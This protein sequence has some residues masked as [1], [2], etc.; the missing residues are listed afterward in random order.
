MHDI[1]YAAQYDRKIVVER[2]VRDAREIECAV[3]G[4][5]DPKASVP[6]EVV[7][8]NEFYDYDAKYVDGKSE[9]IIP[10][11]LDKKTETTL[12]EYA[13]RAFKAVDCSGMA[14]VD[15]FVTRK[16]KKVFINEVNTIPG[17]TSISMYPKMWQAS[18]L[19]YAEL[20][21]EL[22]RL[23]VERWKEK[24]TLLTTYKPKSPWHRS[25]EG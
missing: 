23:A 25:Q 9:V 2:G 1:E 11:D 4:N 10:A 5:D 14:R 12:R 18:G 17:F 16:T 6:G 20:L 3:L 13:V 24:Q 8:S 19:S 21:D 7:P 22:I 15:F